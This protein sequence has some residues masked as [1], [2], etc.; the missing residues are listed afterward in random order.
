MEATFGLPEVNI[1]PQNEFG[2]IARS[3][4]IRTARNWRTV[5]EGTT[6]K[7]E[8]LVYAEESS[9]RAFQCAAIQC[10]LKLLQD[11]QGCR[12]LPGGRKDGKAVVFKIEYIYQVHEQ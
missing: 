3:Q 11:C 6:K 1:Y 5:K 10:D 9:L 4:G 8:A 2:D 7:F 12:C